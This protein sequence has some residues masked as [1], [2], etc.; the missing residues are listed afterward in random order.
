MSRKYSVLG[1]FKFAF[2]GLK[3]AIIHEPNF[4]IHTL[5]GTTALI[6]GF[7]LGLS[8]LEWIILAFVIAFVLILELF[9][10]AIEAIVDHLSPKIHPKA[11]EAK[12][13][14]AAAVFVAS[15]FA[16]GVG[17]VIF[18]PKILMQLGI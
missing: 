13:V 12:D 2:A 16:V 10:T 18:L 6:A 8:T 1:S 11:K 7:I 9:N 17:I 4:Q 15:I 3:Q 14:S 5:I